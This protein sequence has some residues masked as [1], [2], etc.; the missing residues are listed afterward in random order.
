MYYIYMYVPQV[1]GEDLI[2]RSDDNEET[3]RKRLE[4]YYTQTQPLVEYYKKQDLHHCLDAAKN[5]DEVWVELIAI[6]TH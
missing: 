5:N 3:L 6:V 2:R 4:S 1:T